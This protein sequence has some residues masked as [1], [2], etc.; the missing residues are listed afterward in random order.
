MRP[1]LHALTIALVAAALAAPAA[2]AMPAN[3]R[4]ATDGQHAKAPAISYV[5]GKHRELPTWSEV[6]RPPAPATPLAAVATTDVDA[7]F[8]WMGL[9]LGLAGAALILAL[10]GTALALRRRNHRPRV[11]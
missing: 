10:A 5:A 1:K 6:P 2:Q 11:A 7:G 4:V 9:A 8:P 3:D